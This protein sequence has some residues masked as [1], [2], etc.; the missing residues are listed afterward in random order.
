M[1]TLQSYV[2]KLSPFYRMR[3]STGGYFIQ[4][5]NELLEELAERRFLPEYRK[6]T[7][8]I[9][10]N[11]SWI[12][13]PS[14][15]LVLEKIY[16]PENYEK[17]FKVEDVEG[18]YK[19]LDAEFDDEGTQIAATAI[20]LPTTTTI[21]VNLTGYTEDSFEN[22]LFYITAGTLAGNGYVLSGNAVSGVAT[23][24]LNFL[25]TMTA[26]LSGAECTAARLVHPDYYLMMRYR[27]LIT[28]MSSMSDEVPIAAQYEKRL[29]PAWLK[30]KAN[31]HMRMSDEQTKFWEDKSNEILDSL[32]AARSRPTT[33]ATGRRLVGY[34][35]VERET[36]KSHPDYSEY[37]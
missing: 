15:L 9:I 34:Q 1:A 19:L 16:D 22:Y 21:T 28:D 8:R 18:K 35:T 30:Y 33:P 29:V 11:L 13:K 3:Y 5:L 31:E 12:S 20:T 27:G 23:T 7:G 17:E 26:A 36:I 10:T 2:D 14:D 25:H 6:E 37:S 4:W 24:T 32:E